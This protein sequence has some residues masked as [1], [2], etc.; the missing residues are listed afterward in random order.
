[1][2][3]SVPFIIGLCLAG[4][5]V[6]GLP[7]YCVLTYNEKSKRTLI[8]KMSLCSLFVVTI[9]LTFAQAGGIQYLPRFILVQILGVFL[10]I[11]GDVIL[12]A[13]ERMK[14]FVIGSVTFGVGHIVYI[15]AFSM[16]AYALIP[17]YHWFNALEIGVFLFVYGI[18]L[19]IVL[20]KRPP[21][22]KLFLAMFAYY[23]VQAVM[24]TKTLVICVSLFS[25]QPLL[26][27]LPAGAI[28]FV[29]SDYMLGM[30]RFKICKKT[31]VFKTFCTASYFV[32]QM[33][34]A[35]GAHVLV[36]M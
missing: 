3:H 23:A 35:L 5:T 33:C 14:Y 25:E 26:V 15:V 11:V 16:A 9:L 29:L 4:L 24:L 34:L 10:G 7:Y 8:Y 13:S 12:G 31:P 19:L 27:L 20:V 6:I 22:H 28:L 18:E 21:F 30:M 17:D 32:A 2:L 1:M 36:C